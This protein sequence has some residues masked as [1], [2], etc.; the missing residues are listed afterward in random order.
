MIQEKAAP[1]QNWDE[2]PGTSAGSHPDTEGAGMSHD[3]STVSEASDEMW[4]AGGD[5]AVHDVPASPS[6]KN[7]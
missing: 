7:V 4:A 6:H 2:T 1:G 3:A 5:V